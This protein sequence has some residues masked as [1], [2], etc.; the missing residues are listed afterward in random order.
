MKH[1]KIYA[2]RGSK[3]THP[4]NTIAAFEEA[5][6]LGVDG[7]E[8]DVHLSRD[9]ELIVIHDEKVDRTTDGE[10]HVRDMTL[11]ELKKL[12]AGSWFREEFAGAKIPVLA[13]VLELLQGTGIKLNV[14][15]KSD[16]I[17]YQGIE[18]KVLEALE[19]YEYKSNAIIS[20]FNHYSLKRVHQLDPEIETAILFM[21]VLYEPWKYAAGIGASALHV[22]APVAYAEVSREAERN[23]YPVRV[24]TINKEEQMRELLDLGVDTIMTDYPEKAM[25]IRDAR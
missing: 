14:E 25:Q 5:V 24:F 19:K 11:E 18:D 10:G 1:T 13:E 4:E 23:E 15:I 8:L 6:R 16:V 12:D 7:I 9:G 21:E 2:H 17:P 3:G 22:Y 20:S